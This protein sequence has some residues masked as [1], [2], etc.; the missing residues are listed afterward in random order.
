M[1]AIRF[2]MWQKRFLVKRLQVT[3]KKI[4]FRLETAFTWEP[5]YAL[6]VFRPDIN[7]FIFNC[8]L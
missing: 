2:K 1:A 3:D 7:F 5:G 6:S 8:N 4:P